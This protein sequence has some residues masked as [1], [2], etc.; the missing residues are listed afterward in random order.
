MAWKWSEPREAGSDGRGS[1]ARSTLFLRLLRARFAR[2]GRARPYWWR[3]ALSVGAALVI[4]GAAAFLV[5]TRA[6]SC[7][8]EG[9][10]TW[11]GIADY[12]PPEAPSFY[13]RDG[14]LVGHLPGEVRIWV[15]IDGFPPALLEA[16]VAV[17]D[18]R[19]YE[20]AGLDLK[21]I[22]RAALVNLRSGGV[23]EGASTIT[24]QLARNL[25]WPR[26]GEYGRW[27]R[28]L[29][30]ARLAVRLERELEKQRILELY[31]NRVYLGRGLYGFGAAARHYYG[32][33]P[34]DLDLSQIATLVGA[35]KTPERY[36]PRTNPGLARE[37]RDVVLAVLE[38]EGIAARE[39][40][41]AAR[42]EPVSAIDDPPSVQGQGYFAAAVSRE[43]RR[44]IPD[45][46]IRSGVRVHTTL[47]PRAQASA[48]RRLAEQIEAIERGSY[49]RFR[50]PVPEGDLGRS[51]GDSD[52]LQG[53]VLAMDVRTGAVR[54]AVGGRS[55]DHS[56]FDRAFLAAR[57]PGSAFK[58][59]VYATALA[60][61][62]IT[63]AEKVDT[64]PIELEVVQGVWAP[65]DEQAVGDRMSVRAALARSS[66][67]AAVRVG[68]AVGPHR[69]GQVAAAL[70]IASRFEPVPASFLGASVL[71]PVELVTAYATFAN[72]GDAVRPH[73]ISR[74]EDRKGRVLYEHPAGSEPVLD[75]RVAYLTTQALR[76]VI[77]GG[78]GWRAR[79]AGYRGPAAG[80][81]GTTDEW[82]D[83]WFVGFNGEL[84]TGVW[85]GF[86]RPAT[87]TERA[88]GGVVAAPVWGR[89]MADLYGD[90]RD[91][92]GFPARPRDMRALEVDASTGYA[93]SDRCAPEAPRTEYFIP[94]TE[95][96]ALCPIDVAAP[97]LVSTSTPSSNFG[98]L[99]APVVRTRGPSG[100]DH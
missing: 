21:G 86:D 19:F 52:Y 53:A 30:E 18:R 78:T 26:L 87:I 11:S 20:H 73:V 90:G 49:G 81:T 82:R 37:R 35:V 65:A 79:E 93:V 92:A 57:Q 58:P 12:H 17:E 42:A 38:Q 54:A 33:A 100:S 99:P 6:P 32:K 95:P 67:W 61:G 3:G 47:D 70:G 80:K 48:E 89:M 62:R 34:A 75:P 45:P 9:C 29:V 16:I 10:P 50:H 51:D 25:W 22:A 77:D 31:L 56:E 98:S 27:R 91:A 96:P 97:V 88:Y 41:A 84:A 7:A 23:R 4:G 14:R 71:R 76:D 24:M 60:E 46:E 83:A 44:L 39:R 72:G 64:S 5:A 36:N 15:P 94:G 43:L 1:H 66:N 55:F 74:I 63:L 13:D 8:E 85:L 28:K 59:I 68:S 69:V 2:V 40:V